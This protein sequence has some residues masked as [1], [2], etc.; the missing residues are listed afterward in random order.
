MY[1]VPSFVHSSQGA[2]GFPRSGFTS[3]PQRDVLGF[4]WTGFKASFP[5]LDRSSLLGTASL[6][7][8]RGSEIFLRKLLSEPQPRSRLA[9]PWVEIRGAR[10]APLHM[11]N[12]TLTPTPRHTL[13][14]LGLG[15]QKNRAQLVPRE[16]DPQGQSGFCKRSKWRSP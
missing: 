11:H 5:N 4:L 13:R 6:L 2:P 15:N 3:A 14:R 1:S 16:F 7:W 8:V 12:L 10:I 9:G